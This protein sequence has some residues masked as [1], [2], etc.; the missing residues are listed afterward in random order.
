MKLTLDKIFPPLGKREIKQPYPFEG[1][2][3]T[4]NGW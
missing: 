1:L 2:S 3:S 4:E